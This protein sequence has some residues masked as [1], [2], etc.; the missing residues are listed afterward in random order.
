M[1]F[2]KP[3]FFGALLFVSGVSTQAQQ[4]F[5][6][7]LTP[8]FRGAAGSE[9]SHW[10]V[11]IDPAQA[12]NFPNLGDQAS[13]DSEPTLTQVGTSTAFVTSTL[14]IYSFS[15]PTAY[16]IANDTAGTIGA[17]N[18][19]VFQ[20]ST[21]GS[22]I[23][24][25]T[26]QL[27]YSGGTLSLS[28]SNFITETRVFS[29]AMGGYANRAAVQWDLTG[30]GITDYTIS[31]A[32]SASSNSFDVG[33]LDTSHAA[34]TEIVPSA[35]TWD[36]GANDGKWSSGANWSATVTA[37]NPNVDN[38]VQPAGG[39]VTFDANAGATV[40][41][42]GDQEIG[43]L[44]IT[45]PGSFALS[46]SSND[47][48]TINT[49]ITANGGGPAADYTIGAPIFLGGHNFIN[50]A[51]GTAL[52]LSGEISGLGAI[53]AMSATGIYKQGEGRLVLSGDNSFTGGVTVS[54]GSLV[55]SGEN[56]F[57]GVAI[58]RGE[59]VVQS[60]APNGVA[61]ALGASS[62]NVD[63]GVDSSSGSAALIIDGN[64][65][66]GRNI[67]LATGTSV[68]I[69]GA[70][71]ATSAS[72]TGNTLLSTTT[73]SVVLRAEGVTDTVAFS[74]QITGGATTNS[75]TKD[76]LGT[77][78]FTGANKDY[79]NATTVAA[80]TLQIASG[81]AFTGA[82]SVSVE[83]GAQLLVH[84]SLNGSGALAVNG[85]TIGGNGTIN[86]TF[87]L[88]SGDVL[89]P[90][91]SV[92]ILG[93]VSETWA[94]GGRLRLEISDAGA[95]AGTGWDLV[96]IAGS[97]SLTATAAGKFTLEIDS[98]TP[99]NDPGFAANFDANA[100][101]SWKFLDASGAI[102]GFDAGAFAFDVSG[103]QNPVAGNFTVSLD[104][105]DLILNYTAVPEPSSA[106]LA[107]GG[108]AI[109][110]NRRRRPA[111]SIR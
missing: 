22:L 40:Q 82:G 62:A 79:S 33:I 59:L 50:L 99:V 96:N 84:G 91:A 27:N 32:A 88:D 69:L 78:V 70:R 8:S 45:R 92:G 71:N 31:F 34:F 94:A 66:V 12:Y 13:A 61:G 17:V 60:D 104:G 57:R 24:F 95:V 48:L 86:R 49:G 21:L 90:G 64:H 9:Y 38:T 76:G 77:V 14:N 63:L 85:G 58:F 51:A 72:F 103:F 56:E 53:E 83:S 54:G 105:N 19:V 42:D 11:F 68:K 52:T 65:N 46:S 73:S 100:N 7:L 55:I 10:D 80:G 41:L 35:R 89:S 36:G 110:L 16:V 102:T 74:G 25:S 20:F 3:A 87:T 28:P 44:R 75:L 5:P 23:D 6:D 18:N 30:L 106:L 107:L 93:T 29:G 47:V 15:A 26:I 4:L 101:Y 67:G 1:A 98:L 37:G 43:E 111:R 39:N 2:S 97:L 109:F 81:T 108:A